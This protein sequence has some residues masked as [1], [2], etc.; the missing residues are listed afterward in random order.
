MEKIQIVDVEDMLP[1]FTIPQLASYVKQYIGTSYRGPI[2]ER[3]SEIRLYCTTNRI[4]MAQATASFIVKRNKEQAKVAVNPLNFHTTLSKKGVAINYKQDSIEMTGA[5][6]ATLLPD[7]GIVDVR[8]LKHKE[9]QVASISP[10]ALTVAKVASMFVTAKPDGISA[11]VYDQSAYSKLVEPMIKPDTMPGAMIASNCVDADINVKSSV[12]NSQEVIV[13]EIAEKMTTQP[14][15]AAKI[16]NVLNTDLKCKGGF[17]KKQEDGRVLLSTPSFQPY[18]DVF[19]KEIQEGPTFASAQK[20][21]DVCRKIRGAD[22]KLSGYLTRSQYFPYFLEPTVAD[23]FYWKNELKGFV[24]HDRIVISSQKVNIAKLMLAALTSLEY[25]GTITIVEPGVYK[26]VLNKEKKFPNALFKLNN[27]FDISTPGQILLD[28]TPLGVTLSGTDYE[29]YETAV[30]NSLQMRTSIWNYAKQHYWVRAPVVEGFNFVMGKRP[31]NL[32]GWCTNHQSVKTSEEDRHKWY[33][34]SIAAN[35]ARVITCFGAAPFDRIMRAMGAPLPPLEMGS[36]PIL[37]LSAA[38][39]EMIDLSELMDDISEVG[40]QTYIALNNSDEG[41]DVKGKEK[42]SEGSS[43]QQFTT[44]DM[45][46]L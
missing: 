29:S 41:K 34:L 39:G 44:I 32:I 36:I 31:H 38:E 46:G 2:E 25:K 22:D 26:S 9:V 12:G 16:V 1:D 5:L 33:R 21:L 35:Y 7:K 10:T 30:K 20:V 17:F 27:A 40:R 3:V 18:T 8:P 23:I 45:D 11:S 37:A 14:Q 28:V 6:V 13:K 19:K 42:E 24:E 4:S 43:V 15:F